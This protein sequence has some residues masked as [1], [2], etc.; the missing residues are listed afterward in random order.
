[1]L[2]V[3]IARASGFRRQFGTVAGG[4]RERERREGDFVTD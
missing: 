3:G 4:E 2:I 1:L